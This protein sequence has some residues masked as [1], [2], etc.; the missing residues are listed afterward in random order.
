[1]FYD[2][3]LHLG[4][5]SHRLLKD[6]DIPVQYAQVVSCLPDAEEQYSFIPQS[7][8]LLPHRIMLL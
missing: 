6:G 1:M 8:E 7:F 2:P 3:L 4:I 5:K